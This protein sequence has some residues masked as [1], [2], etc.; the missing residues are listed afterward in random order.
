MSRNVSELDTTSLR[1]PRVVKLPNW[2]K[3]R[4]STCRATESSFWRDVLLR[5]SKTSADTAKL[6]VYFK[7][8]LDEEGMA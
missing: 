3:F 8:I 7:A 5:P 2:L 1:S 4:F 6:G